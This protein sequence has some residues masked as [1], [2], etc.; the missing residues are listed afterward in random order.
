MCGDTCVGVCRV[1][2]LVEFRR[3]VLDTTQTYKCLLLAPSGACAVFSRVLYDSAVEAGGGRRP[4]SLRC[5]VGLHITFPKVYMQC[6]FFSFEF[7]CFVYFIS[8]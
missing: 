5:L 4:V 7:E 8:V 1:G 2:R 6:L 3:R